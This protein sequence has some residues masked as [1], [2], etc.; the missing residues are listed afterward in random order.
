MEIPNPHEE[1]A[2]TKKARAL[3][4]FIWEL[5]HGSVTAEN[6][7]PGE[8]RAVEH[9]AGVKPSSD[10]TWAEVASILRGHEHVRA[11]IEAEIV[12]EGQADP[13][14]SFEQDRSGRR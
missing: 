14:A 4:D 13:F 3:A 6:L 5:G 9:A 7:N 8:R 1:A 11:R 10:F 12:A 2:R